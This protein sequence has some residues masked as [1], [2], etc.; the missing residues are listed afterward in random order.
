MNVALWQQNPQILLDLCVQHSP[1]HPEYAFP[2]P[3]LLLL[4]AGI[5]SP[6]SSTYQAGD[7]LVKLLTPSKPQFPYL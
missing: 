2:Q 7:D 3:V 4:F 1:S 5:L 6:S